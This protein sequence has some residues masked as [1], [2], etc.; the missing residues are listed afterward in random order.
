[1]G[2]ALPAQIFTN[3]RS[4]LTDE[5][6]E[7][8]IKML[9]RRLEEDGRE[10]IDTLPL[11]PSQSRHL[12]PEIKSALIEDAKLIDV[13]GFSSTMLHTASRSSVRDIVDKNQILTYFT[14]F[15]S[16]TTKFR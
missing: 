2:A 9:T 1:M 15:S 8:G 4:A 6:R 13:Q 12:Q 5:D 11:H 7:K 3:S 14:Q 10:V 16:K